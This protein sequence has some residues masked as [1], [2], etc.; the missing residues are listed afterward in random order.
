[1]T[2]SNK[3]PPEFPLQT[4]LS[5]SDLEKESHHP[6]YLF[7]YSTVEVQKRIISVGKKKNVLRLTHLKRKT[8]TYT[9]VI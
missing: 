4:D 7:Y 5:I 9:H 3:F 8:H 2:L 6:H 1:M